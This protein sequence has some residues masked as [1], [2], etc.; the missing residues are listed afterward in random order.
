M[1][2]RH[3]LINTQVGTIG[4]LTI[5]SELT[6]GI[7][8]IRAIVVG[9][10]LRRDTLTKIGTLLDGTP[11]GIS[12]ASAIIVGLAGSRTIVN[13]IDGLVRSNGANR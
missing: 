5:I 10:A 6:S 13:D 12:K 2:I 9:P 1:C 7:V 4:I 3:S 11:G 8:G